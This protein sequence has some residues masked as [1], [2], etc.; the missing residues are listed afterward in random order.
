LLG[1]NYATTVDSDNTIQEFFPLGGF[2]NLS[3]LARGAISGPHAGVARL[4]YYRRSGD[5]GSMLAMPLYFGGSIEAGNAWQTRSEIS[6]GSLILNGSLF[7]GIDTYIGPLFIGA[8][9]GEGGESS[10]YLF[11]GAPPR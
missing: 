5:T 4:V 2:L 3:G 1:L 10:F 6:T 7:A 11:L 8:G 9:F